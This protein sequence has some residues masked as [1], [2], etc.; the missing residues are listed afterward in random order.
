M[1]WY[2]SIGQI[3]AALPVD[4]AADVIN[5]MNNSN[6]M[7]AQVNSLLYQVQRDP[8]S[9]SQVATQIIAMDG[10][11]GVV[12]DLAGGLPNA[13]K[14]PSGLALTIQISQIQSALP[15]SRWF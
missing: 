4:K 6:E 14:D 12:R 8:A 3:L 10:V 7:V 9:A 1:A 13:A 2:D 15:R 11:P 5:G